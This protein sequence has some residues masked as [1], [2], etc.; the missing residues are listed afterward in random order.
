MEQVKEEAGNEWLAR[1]RDLYSF[2]AV[3]NT[4]AVVAVGPDVTHVSASEALLVS[5][6]G[7]LGLTLLELRTKAVLDF[8]CTLL[9]ESGGS[10]LDL[11]VVALFRAAT[12]ETLVKCL[13]GGDGARG[14]FVAPW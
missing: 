3:L 4:A 2:A 5:G 12:L 10:V 13:V 9:Q 7:V 8:I 11:D 1:M 6:Q 14:E